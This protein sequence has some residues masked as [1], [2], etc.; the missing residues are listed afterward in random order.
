MKFDSV[1]SGSFK[2]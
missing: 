1:N 2:Q